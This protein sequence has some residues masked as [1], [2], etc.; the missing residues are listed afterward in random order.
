LP[1]IFQLVFFRIFHILL[2][3]ASAPSRHGNLDR[4]GRVPTSG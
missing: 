4:L 1:V 3:K 2:F